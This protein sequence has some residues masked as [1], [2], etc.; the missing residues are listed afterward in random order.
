M[1]KRT[2]C[3]DWNPSK[4]SRT[5]PKHPRVSSR[6]NENERRSDMRSQKRSYKEDKPTTSTGIWLAVSK[7][8]IMLETRKL[9]DT[10][11]T[12]LQSSASS[13]Y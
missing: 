6:K 5:G 4:E 2:S 1:T 8:G 12:V 10:M 7:T 3:N 9:G 13:S 11:S